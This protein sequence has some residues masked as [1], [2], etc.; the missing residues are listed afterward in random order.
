MFGA[1]CLVMALVC[2]EG[3]VPPAA[4]Q[5]NTDSAQ[6]HAAPAN[7]APYRVFAPDGLLPGLVPAQVEAFVRPREGSVEAACWGG[8]WCEWESGHV[9]YSLAV[10]PSGAVA[11]PLG[12]SGGAIAELRRGQDLES[13]DALAQCV[14]SIMASWQFPR[15]TFPTW[16]VI[17]LEFDRRSAAD[18]C[19]ER[20]LR[21]E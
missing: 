4:R 5:S 18:R 6:E 13:S 15:A 8:R 3:C 9:E 19:T 7:R 14:E 11:P 10:D 17:Q 2:A 21:R 12:N 20:S 16:M 1:K